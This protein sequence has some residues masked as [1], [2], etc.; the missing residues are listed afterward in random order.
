MSERIGD[1]P[2]AIARVLVVFAGSVVVGITAGGIFDRFLWVLV[3]A[4]LPPTLAAAGLTSH[5][6]PLRAVGAVAAVALSAAIAVLGHGGG[7]V[8]FGEAFTSGPQ[9][10]LSTEWPSPVRA[11]LVGTVA[12]ALAVATAV[13]AELATRR[14]FHLLPLVPLVAAY[15]GAVGLSS[16]I[17]PTWWGLALLALTGVLLAALPPTD[18]LTER[19]DLLRGERRLVPLLALAVAVVGLLTVPV[20]LTAR[21]DPR[22]TDPPASSAPLLDPIEAAR[23]LRNLDPAVDLHVITAVDGEPIPNRWRTAALA[24]YDGQRWSPSLTLRPIGSTLGVAT[25]PVVEAE[26]SFLDDNLSLLPLPGP[27][28]SVDTDVETDAARTVVRLA[29]PPQPGAVVRLEANTSPTITDAIEN[30]IVTRP[31]E[32]STTAF[33]Q[34]A[35]SLAGDGSPVEQLTQLE[36]TMRSGF[37]RDSEVQGGGLQLVLI[38]RF[39]RDTRRGTPEQFATGFALLARSLGI[40]SRV[41]SGFLVE[42]GP[43]GGPTRLSSADA[44]VWPEI[45]LTDGR[46]L[47]FDPAPDDEAT[48]S[49]PQPPEPQVQ[50]PAA[51]QP[52]IAPP[53]DPDTEPTDPDEATTAE[54]D[55]TWSRVILWVLRVGLVLNLVAL[56][57]AI[58]AATIIGLKLHR[59]RRRLRTDAPGDR[60][61]GAWA[62]ATDVLVDA[63]LDIPASSTDGE[64]ALDGVPIVGGAGHDLRRLAS[65]SS[66]ATY[67][68]PR[69]PELLAED[70]V[71][72]LVAVETSIGTDRSRWQRWRRE[73]S[74]RSLRRSTRSPVRV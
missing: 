2:M 49:D 5:S 52:P 69:H 8:A 15:V 9:G 28:I 29:R 53:P 68:T 10:L 18:R 35:R 27:P 12:A 66:A 36:S 48:D 42:P 14:R 38:E 31:V 61:R 64:I 6:A 13:A 72:C 23:A 71:A 65:L 32:E 7:L 46:W 37:V 54:R 11:E 60:I 67:G 24:S 40:E 56:P 63:G 39:L 73:L 45:Q 20:S 58:A 44:A 59:R 22:R 50:T 1:R 25:G 26:V 21:A 3:A 33:G 57:F 43:P 55:T 19:L 17:G 4:S 51:P 47:A 16:P 62:T 30:G 41:A 70:A 34:L 74:L